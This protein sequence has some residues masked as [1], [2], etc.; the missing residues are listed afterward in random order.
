MSCLWWRCDSL[1]GAHSIMSPDH[2]NETVPCRSVLRQ[3]GG[4]SRLRPRRLHGRFLRNLLRN[5]NLHQFAPSS[6][7]GPCPHRA[8]HRNV[9]EPSAMATGQSCKA[10][11]NQ[12]MLAF[13]TPACHPRAI[14]R[15]DTLS[16]ADGRGWHQ[17]AYRPRVAHSLRLSQAASS[18]AV[19]VYGPTQ[20][21]PVA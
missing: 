21:R 8:T 10:D 3:T 5:N 15:V 14:A 1:A 4:P 16:S 17:Q 11:P 7:A 9:R 20:Y 6:A 12:I 13:S 19:N 2:E 18:W